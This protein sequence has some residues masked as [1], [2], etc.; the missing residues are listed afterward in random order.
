MHQFITSL[1]QQ[2]HQV[3]FWPDN[4]WRDPHY[5]QV[6]Q[7]MG[8]EVIYGSGFVRQFGHF[9][10]D[11]ADLY[12]AVLLSRPHVAANYIGDVRQHTQARVVYYGHDLHFRRLMA[13]TDVE[14]GAVL[15]AEIAA[16][17][18]AEL[19]LCKRADI[20]LFPSVE[21]AAIAGALV[22]R[23]D[24]VRGIPAYCFASCELAGA[25]AM[26]DN[27]TQSGQPLQLLFVGG[28]NH[29]PNRDGIAWF[30]ASVWPQLA[31]RIEAR[32]AIAGSNPDVQI[33]ALAADGIDVLGFV[34]DQELLALYARADLVVAPLRYGAGVK[35]KVIEAMARG[36][37]VITT[38][39]GAQGI[40]DAGEMMFI[41]DDAGDF[42]NAIILAADREVAAAKAKKS[43]HFISQNYSTQAMANVLS[44]ALFGTAGQAG[45]ASGVE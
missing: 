7:A 14:P 13:A 1:I 43:L 37:P 17:K 6:L 8:V 40:P 41:A 32:L 25:R 12:D 39:V 16:M 19:D 35:G 42:A 31:G 4:L 33:L 21:E 11:R 5:T 2:G 28:F 23:D 24:A 10:S 34:T 18:S 15:P 27:R 44:D 38:S 36:V 45:A 9:L 3:S 20:A 26:L 22:G 29:A 30:C